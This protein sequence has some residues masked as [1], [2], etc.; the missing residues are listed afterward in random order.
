MVKN[1]VGQRACPVPESR[2]HHHAGLLVDNH[3]IL[4]L[5]NNSNRNIF[6]SKFRSRRTKHGILNQIARFDTV[7]GFNRV[8]IHKHTTI[9]NSLLNLV[10]G[11]IFHLLRQVLVNTHRGLH[12][13][14]LQ[15][16]F[17]RFKSLFVQSL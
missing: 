8:F 6:R 4:I 9:L 10:A 15:G 14:Y 11:G 16:D 17:F 2:V 1:G 7:I 13:A 3:Q 12:L 5:I